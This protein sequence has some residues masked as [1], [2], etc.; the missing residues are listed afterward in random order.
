[1][2]KPNTVCSKCDKPIYRRP[3]D[4]A[5]YK[6]CFCSRECQGTIRKA[7]KIR[8]VCQKCE[9][10]FFVATYKRKRKYCS[11]ACSN[12]ARRGITYTG[13]KLE[14]RTKRRLAELRNRFDF[15]SCMIEGC[16]YNR[17]YRIH[18]LIPGK[19]GGK[20]EI[21]NMFAICPNQHA[22]IHA[23]IIRVIKIS[24]CKLKIMESRALAR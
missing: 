10:E 14:N 2:R 19:E 20:Y 4:L 23:G 21:G 24:D 9:G 17:I 15:N 7:K 1:M 11:H 6:H 18:R 3:S 8:K 22:E 12:K 5:K 16:N 13:D